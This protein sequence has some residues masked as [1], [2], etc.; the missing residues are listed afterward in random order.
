MPGLASILPVLTA[1]YLFVVICYKTRLL[2]SQSEGQ[3]FFFVCAASGLV[4]SGLAHAILNWGW[5]PPFTWWE[6]RILAAI[7]EA[8]RQHVLTFVLGPVMAGFVNL[9]YW[10]YYRCW[11]RRNA[12]S[13]YYPSSLWE[14]VISIHNRKSGSSLHRMLVQTV[15]SNGEKLVLVSMKSRKVYCGTVRRLPIPQQ[16]GDE[17]IEVIPMF[18]ATRN[19]DT[20]KFEQKIQYPAF[21]LWR[22]QR[23][24]AL[25]RSM[26]DSAKEKEEEYKKAIQQELSER[27]AKLESVAKN[28]P[29]DYVENLDIDLWA[30]LIPVRE[31]ETLSLYDEESNERWFAP[32]DPPQSAT[33]DPA[34]PQL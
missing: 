5:F 23:R 1:G 31:I 22:L 9:I 30:K 20:L 21:H 18:S 16:S 27:E 26:R 28:T 11:V 32:P 24:I 25:L 2:A 15:D 12:D 13:K 6:Q 29:R 7:P 17:F 10:V 34:S 14:W 4:M 33:P 8:S 3:R 19:K